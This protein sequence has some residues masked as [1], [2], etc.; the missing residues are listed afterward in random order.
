MFAVAL[1]QPRE[2][3]ATIVCGQ[4][5][6]QSAN[7]F[8]G[9]LARRKSRRL[10]SHLMKA[11]LREFGITRGLLPIESRD[12]FAGFAATS[13]AADAFAV[14]V[15]RIRHATRSTRAT[16]RQSVLASTLAAPVQLHGRNQRRPSYREPTD[17]SDEPPDFQWKR[18]TPCASF[19]DSFRLTTRTPAR[20]PT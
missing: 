6:K 1:V 13:F 19:F 9:V 20:E 12:R 10:H 14:H 15:V 2:K 5:R 3:I 17:P 7:V 8:D 18:Y 16:R 4:A 11:R